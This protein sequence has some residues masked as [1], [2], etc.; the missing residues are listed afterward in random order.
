MNKHQTARVLLTGTVLTV[1][2]LGCADAGTDTSD[3]PLAYGGTSVSLPGRVEAEK[4]D[5]GG[6]GVGF[7]DTTTGNAG[8][9][10]RADNVDIETCT[11]GG[12]NVGYIAAGEWLAYSVKVAAA[13]QYSMTASVASLTAGGKFHLEV[14][15]VNV[16]GTVTF[17]A[18]GG[19]QNWVKVVVPNVTLPAG[20]S[21]V[22][23]VAESA[24]FNLDYLDFAA[25]GQTPY[26]GKAV[27]VPGRVQAENYDVGGA[28]VAYM[29]STVGNA[30][31]SYRTDNVDIQL[32]FVATRQA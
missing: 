30:G 29:D 3:A 31:G 4:Y 5:Q 12:Y 6:T 1:G 19:W 13:G 10:F 28:N 24:D 18:T 27:T 11:A 22:R 32:Q 17:A 21:V 15:G 25:L 9:Q 23:F 26:G 2:A 20:E 16:T 7:Q 14:G 8:G